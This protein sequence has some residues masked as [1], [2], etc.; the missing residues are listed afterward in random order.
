M[1]IKLIETDD[2]KGE[3]TAICK[4]CLKNVK[5]KLERRKKP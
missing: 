1:G 3:T 2:P 5:E 4:K